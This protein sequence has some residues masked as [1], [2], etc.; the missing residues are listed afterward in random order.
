[1]T[2]IMLT[3]NEKNLVAEFRRNVI[4]CYHFVII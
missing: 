3:K 4:I 1:M 2:L